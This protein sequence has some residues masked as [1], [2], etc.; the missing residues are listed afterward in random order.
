MSPT[1]SAVVAPATFVTSITSSGTQP[2]SA[3][4]I[5]TTAE[6]AAIAT[7]GAAPSIC[8]WLLSPLPRGPH[9]QH[10][11]NSPVRILWL[12]CTHI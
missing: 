1:S 4:A 7:R 11:T 2:V 3:A 9:I 5:A 6:R 8:S 10:Y 12:L